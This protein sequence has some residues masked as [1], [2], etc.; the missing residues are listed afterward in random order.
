MES[1][2]I[3]QLELL[4]DTPPAE[5]RGEAYVCVG[6]PD[7]TVRTRIFRELPHGTLLIYIHQ[8]K[9]AQAQD[10]HLI[11]LET[12]PGIHEQLALILNTLKIEQVRFA[13]V[14]NDELPETFSPEKLQAYIRELVGGIYHER[15]SRLVNLRCA[16]RNLDALGKRA[17]TSAHAPDNSTA[18]VCGSGPSL[19]KQLPALR[20]IQDNAYIIAI[21][22]LAPRLL[23]EGIC[24]DAVVFAD[25]S[26]YGLDWKK[27]FSHNPL[28]IAFPCSAPDVVAAAEKIFFVQS[29]S[30]FFNRALQEW[31]VELPRLHFSGTGT[32][33]GI[34]FAAE[35]GFSRI[36]LVGNDLCMDG[37]ASHISGYDHEERFVHQSFTVPG[38]DGDTV[39]TTRELDR[40]RQRLE[41]YLANKQ[42]TVYNCGLRGAAINGSIRMS[43]DTLM[44]DT[45]S[46]KPLVQLDGTLR[47][48]PRWS[49]HFER[50]AH[51]HAE[52][53]LRRS[54]VP[55][56]IPYP[57]YREKW[58]N[59]LSGQLRADFKL[60]FDNSIAKVPPS[61]DLAFSAF[62]NFTRN[63]VRA[64]NPKLAEWLRNPPPLPDGQEVYTCFTEYAAI[65][66]EH[67][68]IRT[69]LS[70]DYLDM[71]GQAREE[72]GD[73]C[74]EQLF[75]P[76][77]QLMVFIEP[78][79]WQHVTAFAETWPNA[80]TVCVILYP[81]IFARLG[82]LCLFLHRIP[83]DTIVIAADDRFPDWKRL[84]HSALRNAR[85]Q[86]LQPLFHINPHGAKLPRI[87][88]LCAWLDSQHPGA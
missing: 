60:D 47:F 79:S 80:K 18:I 41:N 12:V 76:A 81:E 83:R 51:E 73:F 87:E 21:G 58:V 61:D 74:R 57:Q 68:Y 39:T 65:T 10:I 67:N 22:K 20:E 25:Y 45:A 56:V 33:T 37:S 78:G 13:R 62:S 42:L 38:A 32:I 16:L 72:I 11:S 1:A 48:T 75:N 59:D 86:G 66:V 27:L 23:E 50:C 14:G 70:G 84:L 43:L 29:P 40:L 28:L 55:S 34:D 85:R 88:N 53:L 19:E 30:P 2:L 6:P 64:S 3:A 46:A 17:V 49:I 71:T 36:A 82:S 52:H 26:G 8:G 9:C 15:L 35:A 31:N 69:P 4:L 63:F 54:I 24:P 77:Q 44:A 7:E 5:S